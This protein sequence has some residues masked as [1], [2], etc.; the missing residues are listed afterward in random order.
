MRRRKPEPVDGLLLLDKPLGL[1]SHQAVVKAR[2]ALNA[3][4]AGHTG[5]LD[6]L[7]TGMLPIAFGLATRLAGW[8]LDADKAYRVRARLGVATSTGDLEGEV[9]A[10]HP[11]PADWPQRLAALLP[12]F[13]GTLHQVPP[14]HSA[15]KRGGKPAYKLARAG[16]EVALEARLIQIHTLRSL[17]TGTDWAELEVVCGKG[18]YIR[19]LVADLGAALGC[20]A[21][22]VAL[23]RS[24]VAPFIDQPMWTIDALTADPAGARAALLPAQTMI[25]Q[26]PRLEVGA[27][28]AERLLHGQR[29][30][31]YRRL[32]GTGPLAVI[33]PDRLL[34]LVSVDERG[35][36]RPL[37]ILKN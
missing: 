30:A 18:T 10:E 12:R 11:L 37:R 34:G 31:G 3:E 16:I 32:A 33:G 20:G 4:S 15:I 24:W 25:P 36:L 14:R 8:M 21:H 27:A 17:Q 7:A 2:Q 22:V 28:I 5:T 26:L 6:P 19:S 35:V 13:I 9:V 1:T 23:H 29:I